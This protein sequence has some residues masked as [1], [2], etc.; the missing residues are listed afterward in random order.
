M[1]VVL[2][3]AQWALLGRL[4]DTFWALLGHSWALLGHSWALWGTL[5]DA[6]GAL[7][8]T[9]QMRLAKKYGC[10]KL[11]EAQLGFQNGA[12]LEPKSI[13]KRC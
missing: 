6:L 5:L 9:S 11:F 3:G 2:G 7:L 12:K 4:L 8:G 10:D 13:E 1:Q